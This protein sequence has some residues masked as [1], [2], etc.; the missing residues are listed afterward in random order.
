MVQECFSVSLTPLKTN[1]KGP[2]IPESFSLIKAYLLK[3]YHLFKGKVLSQV[4]SELS[5]A[6]CVCVDFIGPW[7][8]E[9]P[10]PLPSLI[11][12]PRP[13]ASQMVLLYWGFLRRAGWSPKHIW[14]SKSKSFGSDS[15]WA[16]VQGEGFLGSSFHGINFLPNDKGGGQQAGLVICSSSC[17]ARGGG[18]SAQWRKSPTKNKDNILNRR[19]HLQMTH[20]YRTQTA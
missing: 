19:R 2:I 15:G 3:M 9:E 11:W 20:W 18:F 5:F 8:Q 10:F 13:I 4:F 7:A 14:N 17:E 16:G 6:E 12:V 1:N